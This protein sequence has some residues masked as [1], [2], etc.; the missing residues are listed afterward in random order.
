MINHTVEQIYS[1]LIEGINGNNESIGVIAIDDETF[2]IFGINF[3]INS[4]EEARSFIAGLIAGYCKCNI[5]KKEDAF[6]CAE[7]GKFK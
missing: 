5:Y 6:K 1:L 7:E 4:K 3:Q 2:K